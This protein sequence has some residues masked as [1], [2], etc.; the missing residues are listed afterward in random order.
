VNWLDLF[1]FQ[2]RLADLYH[3]AAMRRFEAA[4]AILRTLP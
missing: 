1:R 2:L 3:R 4:Q